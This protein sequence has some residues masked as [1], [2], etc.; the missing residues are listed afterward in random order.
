MKVSAPGY[1]DQS[2]SKTFKVS[3]ASLVSSSNIP[4]PLNSFGNS[5]YGHNLPSTI[6]AI[7]FK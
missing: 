3:P 6:I 2:A 1:V 7:P 5:T 4:I